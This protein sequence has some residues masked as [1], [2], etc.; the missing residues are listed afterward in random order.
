MASGRSLSW[1]NKY[2]LWSCRSEITLVF[3]FSSWPWSKVNL[4]VLDGF[5]SDSVFKTAEKRT[6]KPEQANK[7]PWHL[8][9][10]ANS[11]P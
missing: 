5:S 11:S 9:E 8:T 3:Q 1:A 4:F 10:R 6:E 2:S 7:T